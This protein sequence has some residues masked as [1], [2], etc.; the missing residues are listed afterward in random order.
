MTSLTDY[1]VNFNKN[2]KVSFNGGDL[3][4][5]AGLLIPRSFD[6]T[7]GAGKI[8][9]SLH[10]ARFSS[11]MAALKPRKSRLADRAA[12]GAAGGTARQR[13]TVRFPYV[14]INA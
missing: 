6:E 3:S 4:S 14:I 9:R 11:V 12:L 5:D 8:R 7:L 1:A 10:A 2:L 13:L